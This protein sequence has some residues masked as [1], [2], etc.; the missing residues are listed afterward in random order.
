MIWDLKAILQ[1][2][3]IKNC[4]VTTKDIDL[5]E[6]I[7][8]PDIASLKGKRTWCKLTPVV[9]DIIE[10]PHELME[11]Q[12]DIDLCFNTLYINKLPFLVTVSKCILYC[13]I[14]WLPDETSASYAKALKT[15]I[16]LYLQADFQIA[17]MSCD[18]EYHPLMDLLDDEYQAKLNF[19]SAQ[20]HVPEAECNIWVIKEWVRAV[21]HG[22][23]FETIL[24]IMIKYLA[25]EAIRKLIFSTQ[26]WHLTFLQSTRDFAS[27]EAW[28]HQALFDHPVLV[29]S[30]TQ[31]T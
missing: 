16:W 30:S 27:W 15:V 13:T 23:P 2:N 19:A 3:M 7:F 18:Q 22:L 6:K 12:Q 4:P 20:E 28:L 21:F 26:G 10:I 24:A 31:R 9:Q 14:K 17:T 11:A 25:I 5:A 1:M 29:C 8:G